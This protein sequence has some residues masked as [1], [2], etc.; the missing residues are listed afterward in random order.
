MPRVC[1]RDDDDD[2]VLF[3]FVFSLFLFLAGNE[4]VKLDDGNYDTMVERFL[5][6]K[7]TIS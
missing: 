1:A 6:L 5:F 4:R 3:C 2:D 7:L